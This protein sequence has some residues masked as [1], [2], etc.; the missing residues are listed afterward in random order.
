MR[1]NELRQKSTEELRQMSQEFRRSLFDLRFKQHTGQ[2]TQ[3][4][5]LRAARRDIARVETILR[6]RELAQQSGGQK[7]GR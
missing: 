1:A 7:G 4:H 3:T 5:E 2:L 6:E